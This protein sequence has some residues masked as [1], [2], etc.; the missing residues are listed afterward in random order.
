MMN[1]WKNS[2]LEDRLYQAAKAA[3]AKD[4]DR[5]VA[6]IEM[7]CAKGTPIDDALESLRRNQPNLY[8][9]V[10]PTIERKDPARKSKATKR[11]RRYDDE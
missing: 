6:S 10:R 9:P 5:V 2:R 7:T 1:D 11:A 3:G 8:Y 4:V